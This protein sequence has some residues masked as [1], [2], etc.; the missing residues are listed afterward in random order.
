MKYLKII[1]ISSICLGI[2]FKIN[3]QEYKRITLQS[4]ASSIAVYKNKKVTLVLRLKHINW[5]FKK[6]TFYD[7]NN[8]DITF[9]IHNY[10]KNPLLYASLQNI[11]NGAEYIVVCVIHD[12]DNDNVLAS[13]LISFVPLYL[14][15]LP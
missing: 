7:L 13:A 9:D 15:Q 11:H 2:C 8:H 4:I 12:V 1:I 14:E 3:A 5:I 10:Q 6:V